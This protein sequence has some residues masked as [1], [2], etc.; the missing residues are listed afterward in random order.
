MAG[1]SL[2]WEVEEMEGWGWP[3]ITVTAH[4]EGLKVPRLGDESVGSLTCSCS[5]RQTESLKECVSVKRT[6]WLFQV[7]GSA[8]SDLYFGWGK[9]KKE[10][11]EVSVRYRRP[12]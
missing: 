6:S 7:I 5:D 2:G 4:T 9:K 3:A 1:R 12:Q 11:L 8:L 10:Q